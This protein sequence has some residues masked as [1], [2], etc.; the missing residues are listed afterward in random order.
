MLS[1]IRISATPAKRVAGKTRRFVQFGAPPAQPT[2]PQTVANPPAQ[3]PE[4]IQ[5][6][7]PAQEKAAA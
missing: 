7:A 2:Q 6:P 5:K 3:N 4:P 1:E